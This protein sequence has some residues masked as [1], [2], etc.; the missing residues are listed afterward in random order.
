MVISNLNKKPLP[1]NDID[2]SL[3][4]IQRHVNSRQIMSD[5]HEVAE[6]QFCKHIIIQNNRQFYTHMWVTWIGHENGI[7]LTFNE[8]FKDRIL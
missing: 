6:I 4:F 2:S 3:Y 1:Q 8:T 7:L 5:E